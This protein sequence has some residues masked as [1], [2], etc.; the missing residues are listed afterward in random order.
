MNSRQRLEA[1]LNHRPVDRVCVD[2]GSTA[3]TGIAASAVSRLRKALLNDPGYR[4]KIVEPYQL[5]GEIDPQLHAKL[6]IDVVGLAG[7]KTMFGFKNKNW[8]NFELFD[9]TPVQVPGD[10]NFTVAENGDLLIHPQGDLSV[11]PSGRLPKGG[12][13]FDAICRQQPIIEDKLD[14]AD[15]FEE[16]GVLS[17]SDLDYYSQQG[18]I[19]SATGK[20]VIVGIPGTAFGDIALVPAVWMKQVKGIRDIEEWYISTAIRKD[21]IR[22]V[23]EKQLEYGLKNIE[24]IAKVVGDVAQAAVVSGTDFGTQRGLFISVQSYRELFKPYHKQVNDFIHK[25][26]KWKTFI[27]SCGSIV[28]L[29]PDLIEAGFDILNPVQCSAVGM[30][31]ARLKKEF[32]KDLVFWGGGVDTQQTLAFGKPEEVYNEVRQRIDIFNQD[33]GF[34][35]DAIHNIQATT[36]LEN[37]LA[38]FK[39]IRDSSK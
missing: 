11:P 7:P 29:I 38:M 18:K 14:P 12:Y 35:F 31:P 20:G 6:E 3:V 2:F 25:H 15:N 21:Y 13:Y 27:H 8:K 4:V 10:F 37:M 9:G 24:S 32:G 33:G 28:E 23:F 19:A 39:A 30:D 34:V 17:E 26:T 36:P 1:V 16:F 22:S 5:L